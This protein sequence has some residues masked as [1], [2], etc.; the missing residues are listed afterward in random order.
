MIERMKYHYLTLLFLFFTYGCSDEI[1]TATN[2][3]AHQTAVSIRV[4]PSEKKSLDEIVRIAQPTLERTITSLDAN[5][6]N[7]EIHKINSVATYSRWPLSANTFRILDLAYHYAELTGGAYDFTL[8][9]LSDLWKKGTELPPANLIQATLENTGY[10]HV[11]LFDDGAVALTTP[12]ARIDLGSLA[13]SYA[14]D[15]S[16]IDV[17]R[18]NFTNLLIRVGQSARCL[19]YADKNTPWE[20]TLYNP[21]D[22]KEPIGQVNLSEGLAITHV[23]L[24][25]NPILDSRTGKP[26]QGTLSVNVMGPTATEAHALAQALLVVGTQGAEEMMKKFPR[27]ESLIVPQKKS[28]E[29]WMTPEFAKRFTINPKYRDTLHLLGP[30]AN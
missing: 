17:R 18:H 8:A 6:P 23:S 13:E 1:P 16:L 11:T 26:A 19:G 9:P 14:L 4:A 25:S 22:R 20:E 28:L 3:S 30:K 15:L 27:Y 29:L 7:S 10:R 5:N 2:F 24:R 21:L 12:L